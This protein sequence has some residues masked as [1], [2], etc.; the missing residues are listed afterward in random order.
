MANG[1]AACR[2]DLEQAKACIAEQNA[3]IERFRAVVRAERRLWEH[4]QQDDPDY[5]EWDRLT[6]E[7]NKA[8]D[9]IT[10]DDM[11]EV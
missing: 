9:A 7:F 6:D 10:A 4:S 2:D 3:S 1:Y 11:G 5:D 8:Q